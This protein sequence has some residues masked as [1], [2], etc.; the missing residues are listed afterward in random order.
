MDFV[1][2][3]RD[4]IR[5][6]FDNDPGLFLEINC[7]RNQ[8]FDPVHLQRF[9]A[10]GAAAVDFD[11]LFDGAYALTPLYDPTA[12]V[13]ARSPALFSFDR[14]G[15]DVAIVEGVGQSPA[16]PGVVDA[17]AVVETLIDG[18]SALGPVRRRTPQPE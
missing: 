5:V 18:I 17:E 6:F 16:R 11:A 7:R 3:F 2:L 10:G 14:H 4:T 12:L 13:L 1:A 8:N 15:S 9:E